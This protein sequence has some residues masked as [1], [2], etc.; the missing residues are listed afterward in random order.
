MLKSQR[1]SNSAVMCFS[2]NHINL[3][4]HQNK[5]IKYKPIFKRYYIIYRNNSSTIIYLRYTRVVPEVRGP[6][7]Y[8]LKYECM[9]INDNGRPIH[10]STVIDV[11]PSWKRPYHLKTNDQLHLRPVF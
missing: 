10:G 2:A 4:Q 6:L 11:R 8:K 5:I 1:F 3:G 7:P 9:S